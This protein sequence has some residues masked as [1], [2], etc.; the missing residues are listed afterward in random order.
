MLDIWWNILIKFS[1]QIANTFAK[2][3][4][5]CK[6]EFKILSNIWDGAFWINS[7]KLTPLYYFCKNFH[8]G[9]LTRFWICFWI[10]FQCWGCFIFKSI[11]ISKVADN[12][13]LG[14]TKKKERN[15]L[16]LT[17]KLEFFLH[18]LHLPCFSVEAHSEPPQTS[19]LECFL[20]N[21]FTTLNR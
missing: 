19:K 2:I 13:L 21:Q 15:E 4:N 18:T 14:K 1:K 3:I 16:Q 12:L 17:K 20:R 9:C 7:Q 8:L 5:G 11:W 10:G 6:G